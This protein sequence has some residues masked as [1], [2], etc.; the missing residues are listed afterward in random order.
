MLLLSDVLFYHDLT[1]VIAS[2]EHVNK[3]D[4]REGYAGT[5]LVTFKENM[6]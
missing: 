5:R 3:D 1:M 4:D 2:L 6:L